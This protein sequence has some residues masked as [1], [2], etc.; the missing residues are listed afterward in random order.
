MDILNKR[1]KRYKRFFAFG[2]SFTNYVWPT[3]ADIVATE[4]AGAEFFNF[5]L[6]GSGN[7][8]ISVRIAEANTRFKFTEDDL[9]MVLFTSYTREDRWVNGNWLTLG[10]VFN[11]TA[12]ND[13]WVRNFADEKGY[14]IRDLGLIALTTTYLESLPCTSFCMK[15]ANFTAKSDCPGKNPPVFD[16]LN[17]VYKTVIDKFKHPPLIPAYQFGPTGY[18]FPDGHPSTLQ[19]LNFLKNQGLSFSESTID[20]VKAENTKLNLVKEKTELRTVFPY[21][22]KKSSESR[23]LLF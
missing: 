5:G 11:Q 17:N 7:L 20:Y 18:T 23:N 21:Q 16:D 6:S 15:A 8:A 12:Y 3:W 19:Y 2:C 1:Y 9:V 13:E 14:L 22:D 10:N 4:L